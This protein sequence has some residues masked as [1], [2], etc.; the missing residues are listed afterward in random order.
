LKTFSPLAPI[1]IIINDFE[2]EK[3]VEKNIIEAEA[4]QPI[5]TE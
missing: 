4:I 3:H 2:E 5:E 1:I